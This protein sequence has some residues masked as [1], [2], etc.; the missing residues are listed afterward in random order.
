M[1]LTILGLLS[2]TLFVGLPMATADNTLSSDNLAA[3]DPNGQF[4]QLWNEIQQLKET[5]GE[6]NAALY[7]RFFEL[8]RTVYPDRSSHEGGRSLDQGMDGCPGY[9]I[10]QPVEGPI[11]YV[12][13]GQTYNLNNDCTFPQCRTG[14]DV[15]YQLVMTRQDSLQITTCGSGFDTYLCIFSGACC[16]AGSGPMFSNDDSPICGANSVRS[17][18]RACFQPGQYFIVVD[19]FNGTA[20]GHYQLNIQS[21]A[22]GI[23]GQNPP[24]ECPP[25]FSQ[26]VEG[27]DEGVCEFGT[28]ISCPARYCGV[29]GGLGDLDVYTFTLT[30]CYIVTLS[31]WGNDTPGHSST[32][33][34]LNPV[35]NL[36]T[37]ACDRP[38]YTNDDVEG[39][40]GDITGHD[41][42]IVTLCLRPATYWVEVSG[43]ETAG[44]YEFGLDCAPCPS[45]P[46]LDNVQRDVPGPGCLSWAIQPGAT[47][48]YVWRSVQSGPWDLV[49]TTAE[50]TYCDHTG[51]EDVSTY[52]VFD[53]PCGN[54]T[55]DR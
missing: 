9:V 16:P 22:G 50:T 23:C 31:V 29:I 18:V 8:E 40:P 17:A 11:D 41:S 55:F 53:N 25:D 15:I 45:V 30:N 37:T 38:I 36:Y 7:D 35:L 32:G 21:L 12:D 39:N 33:H 13:Y 49:F 14:R 26:H 48:Y 2:V 44:L 19:G 3:S 27:G 54:P 24:L 43:N 34:G 51:S 10:Q 6:I 20:Q 1:K 42:R 47:T 46:P 28:E 4:L 5:D 52:M